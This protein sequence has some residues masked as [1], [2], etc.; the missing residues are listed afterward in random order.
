LAAPIF[1]SAAGWWRGGCWLGLN[2]GGLAWQS[3][4]FS[5]VKTKTYLLLV[6][7]DLAR[8]ANF[9]RLRMTPLGTSCLEIARF[10]GIWSCGPMFCQPCGFRREQCEALLSVPI[11][12]H[13]VPW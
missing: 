2:K 10:D 5:R 11:M 4:G 13:D 9:G 1:S 6:F 3:Y 8:V 12:R 7:F